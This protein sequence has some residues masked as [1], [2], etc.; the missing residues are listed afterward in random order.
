MGYVKSQN[1]KQFVVSIGADFCCEHIRLE[2]LC[3]L[4]RSVAL[5]LLSAGPLPAPHA[6]TQDYSA[7]WQRRHGVFCCTSAAYVSHFTLL[8]GLMPGCWHG[9]NQVDYN[10]HRV[11]IAL[12]LSPFDVFP[13]IRT[14]SHQHWH[15]TTLNSKTLTLKHP[16][17]L[18]SLLSVITRQFKGDK[19]ET[20]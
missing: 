7:G 16:L 3:S 4:A 12:F 2:M 6:V 5:L 17:L 20:E 14:A 1:A 11:N 18:F 13:H 9:S 8:L 10:K 15:F 19:Q